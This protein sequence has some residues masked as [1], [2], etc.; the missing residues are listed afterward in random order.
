MVR[1]F[2]TLNLSFY[3][4]TDGWTQPPHYVFVMSTADRLASNLHTMIKKF[5]FFHDSNDTNLNNTMNI[6]TPKS[7]VFKISVLLFF[8][9]VL[10]GVQCSL[11]YYY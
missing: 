7:F 5:S 4:H 1:T 11:L 2:I 6:M 8:L 10:Y 3:I 9:S